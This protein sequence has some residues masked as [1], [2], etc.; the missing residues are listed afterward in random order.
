MPRCWRAAK[1]RVDALSWSWERRVGTALGAQGKV[2]WVASRPQGFLLH[3]Q[4]DLQQGECPGG[5][6]HLSS[7]AEMSWTPPFTH[8]KPIKASGCRANNDTIINGGAVGT[9]TAPPC[10]SSR[11]LLR[12]FS[13]LHKVQQGLSRCCS[14]QWGPTAPLR[15]PDFSPGS[16]RADGGG[17][18]DSHQGFMQFKQMLNSVLSPNLPS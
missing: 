14:R 4:R 2:P 13:K 15:P 8:I 7:S 10:L 12:D 16:G 5:P 17:R 11:H 6:R 9:P 3:L 1:T 18:T